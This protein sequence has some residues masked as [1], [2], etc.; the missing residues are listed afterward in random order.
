M[1]AALVLLGLSLN[2][3]DAGQVRYA[4]P[5]ALA[6]YTWLMV[7]GL[8]GLFLRYLSTERAWVRWLA[9]SAY[10][11]YVAS[12]PPAVAFQYLVIDWT[13]PAAGKLLVVFVATTA[14]VLVSYRLFVRYTWIGRLLNG[15][16]L[17]AGHGRPRTAPDSAS[18]PVAG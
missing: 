3:A 15:P 1:P 12:L 16:R 18:V 14:T 6:L 4:L 7:G 13:M 9:D 11:C 10:W 17:K 5:A 8:L 2:A